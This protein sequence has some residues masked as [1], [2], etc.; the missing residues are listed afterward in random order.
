MTHQSMLPQSYVRITIITATD[1]QAYVFEGECL[2][3][4]CQACFHFNVSLTST[5]MSLPIRY[6]PMAFYFR[7]SIIFLTPQILQHAPRQCDPPQP[8]RKGS[9]NHHQ[10][11]PIPITPSVWY[12]I[13]DLPYDLQTMLLY[14]PFLVSSLLPNASFCGPTDHKSL[15]CVV[16]TLP[17]VSPHTNLVLIL[18]IVCI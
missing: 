15:H 1:N 10:L 4:V 2:T 5:V 3:M 13:G 14:F 17:Y 16:R 11:Y 6:S 7:F 12:H 18:L 9:P 8:S